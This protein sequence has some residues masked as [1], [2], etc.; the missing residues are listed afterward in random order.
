MTRF[1]NEKMVWLNNPSDW[2]VVDDTGE[3]EGSGGSFSIENEGTIL[4]LS[5]PACKDF[6]ARTFYTPLLIKNDASGLLCTIS[7][8]EESTIYVDFEYT[9]VSQ[10][11]QV[12]THYISDSSCVSA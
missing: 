10:F 4:K 7:S 8:E 3:L 11:D 2:G 9:P 1:D 5:P 6:W 12:T